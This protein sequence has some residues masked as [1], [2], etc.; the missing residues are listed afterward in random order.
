MKG[1]RYEQASGT[2]WVVNGGYAAPVAQ[3]YSG[4]GVGRDNPERQHERNVGPLPQGTYHMQQ[5]VN[6]RFV[7]PAIKVTQIEGETF[8]RSGF[9]I[10]GDNTT[11][12][13]S[14]GCIVVDRAT[15]ECIAALMLNGFRTLWVVP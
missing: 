9:W 4:R 13:T 14:E 10:H 7:S 8:G 5:L 15:R 2:L 12:D 3:G 1:F 11:R 6:R